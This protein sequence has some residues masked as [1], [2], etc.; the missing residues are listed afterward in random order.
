LSKNPDPG[1]RWISLG[2]E[3]FANMGFSAWL[4]WWL[5]HRT[6]SA[7]ALLATCLLGL[8]IVLYRIVRIASK[9]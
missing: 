3:I 5:Y 1:W 6:G 9:P 2:V 8:A 7:L 4:G